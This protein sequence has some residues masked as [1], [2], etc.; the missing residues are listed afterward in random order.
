[1]EI[2]EIHCEIT[3]IKNKYFLF[4]IKNVLKKKLNVIHKNVNSCM[5]C[6]YKNH[7]KMYVNNSSINYIYSYYHINL[8]NNY[9]MKLQARLGNIKTYYNSN[10]VQHERDW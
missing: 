4:I 5:N 7:I 9:Y 2:N 8:F 6:T 3:F 10:Y 1:M